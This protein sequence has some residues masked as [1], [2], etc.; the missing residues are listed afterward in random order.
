LLAAVAERIATVSVPG[1]QVAQWLQD[2]SDRCF[3]RQRATADD[4][5]LVATFVAA[6]AATLVATTLQVGDSP[7]RLDAAATAG[8]ALTVGLAAVV[9]WT[10][11]LREADHQ[12]II[13]ASAGG[14]SQWSSERLLRELRVATLA[15]VNGNEAVV[16]RILR[17]LTTQLAIA[18]ATGV[19]AAVSLLRP[20][21][22]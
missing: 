18:F 10:D 17:W 8:L 14:G 21:L 16:T 2:Q 12:A 11:T 4:A 3:A 22:A 15:A 9:V 5:K 6:V 19:V 7:T 13:T 1:E 20:L